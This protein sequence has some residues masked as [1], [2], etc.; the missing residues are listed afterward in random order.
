LTNKFGGLQG[1]DFRSAPTH[2]R[3]FMKTL[4]PSQPVINFI[5]GPG[6]EFQSGDDD[7]TTPWGAPPMTQAERE[8]LGWGRVEVRPS[9]RQSYD[10]FL[11]VIQFGDANSLMSMAP[12]S[13]VDSIDGKL[14]GTHVGDTANQWVVMLARA[15]SDEFQVRDAAYSFKAVAPSSRQLLLDM[16]RSTTFHVTVSSIGP[17]TRVE[18]RTQAAGGSTPVAS[19]GQGVLSFEVNGTQVR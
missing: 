8:Y 10:L 2:G 9:I 5:G 15:V 19:N 16:A 7:A 11:N 14:T 17:D 18:V 6:M 12:I 13:R 4:W 3:F 1:K